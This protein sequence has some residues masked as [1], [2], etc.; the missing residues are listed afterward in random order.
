MTL[1]AYP[2]LLANLGAPYLNVSPIL[3]PG[4]VYFVN[5][6]RGKSSNDGRDSIRPMA[7]FQ[8]AYNKCRA[9]RGDIVVLL[10]GHTETIT[11]AA[12]WALG[13]AG[14]TVLAIGQGANR[15]TVTLGTAVGASIDVTAANN[16]IA[17]IGG[18]DSGL[19]IDGTGVDAITAVMNVS[20]ASFQFINNRMILANATGQA[21]LGILTTAAA[22]RMRLYGN[23]F[24]GTVDAGTATAIRIVGGDQAIIDSNYI[25][26]AYTTTLGGIQNVTTAC[27]DILIVANII[28]NRTAA[29][30]VAI[31]M[32]A[33]A[34]GI[35]TNNRL[36]VLAGTAPVVFAAGTNGGGNYY[37]AAAG[38]T[39][40]TLL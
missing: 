20:A 16:M 17:G 37:S 34:T 2:G 29:S 27:T 25:V 30:S 9:N 26:G 28:E 19:I 3:T 1:T 7:A 36:S 12:G 15:P 40:G 22:D 8:A 10:P 31:T 35:F 32:H 21:T 14:V 38:V 23:R 24:E 5:S 6:V 18:P 33:S 4:E 39:A 11:G 13:T